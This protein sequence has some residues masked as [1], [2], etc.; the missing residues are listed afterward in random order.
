MHGAILLAVGV[1][2][3]A[4]SV[5]PAAASSMTGPPG[6]VTTSTTL[7][8][9]GRDSRDQDGEPTSGTPLAPPTD[10][11]TGRRHPMILRAGSG[12][13]EGDNENLI[14]FHKQAPGHGMEVGRVR[15]SMPGAGGHH[16]ILFRPH[17]GVVQWPPKLCPITLNYDSWELIAQTQHP[18]FDW[19][20]PPG[21]AINIAP[22]QPLLIQTHYLRSPHP[23][24]PRM[25]TKTKLYPVDPATVT[26]HA[27]ALFLNDRAVVAP[28]GHSVA[29]SRCTLTGEGANAREL[30]IIG[31]T[32][33]YHFRGLGFEVYRVNTDGSLGELLYH[34]EGFD[35]PNFHQYDT[36]IVLQAG[37]GIEWRCIYQ[38]NTSNTFTFGPDASTQEHCI[39]FGAYYPTSTPQEAITCVHDRDAEGTDVDTV[40]VVPGE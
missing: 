13:L 34:Y 37:E 25:M 16:V 38:N 28:P 10:E 39:L 11:G 7:P 12:P 6:V 18:D 8:H 4:G 32:G 5:P 40:A 29:V 22:R 26:A 35:Q 24:K 1:M 23:K 9:S 19:K 20:L 33:H 15:I 30:K 3:G 31:I 17:P 2:L 21:V 36:P 27:G 14:C